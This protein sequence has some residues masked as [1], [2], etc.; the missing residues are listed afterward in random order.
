MYMKLSTYAKQQGVHYQTAYNWYR[1][2][3][4]PGAV[5]HATGTILVPEVSVNLNKDIVIYVRVDIEQKS[6]LDL[7]INKL[8]EFCGT[9]GLSISREYKEMASGSN[10]N[11]KQFWKMINSCPNII[12]IESKNVLVKSGFI[13]LEYFLKKQ[14]CEIIVMNNAII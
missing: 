14:G 9:R 8:R 2:G 5:Q 12:V 1:A 7:Q 4:I 13:Y 10:E 3:L 6:E 11:R